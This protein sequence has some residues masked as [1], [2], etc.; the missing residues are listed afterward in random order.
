MVY[1]E[2][3]S[4]WSQQEIEADLHSNGYDPLCINETPD[5]RLTPHDHPRKHI[6]VVLNG[7]IH[8]GI[9]ETSEMLYSGDMAVIEPNVTHAA[10]FGSE[11]CRY[12]W[13]EQ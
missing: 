13:V 8:L 5:T 12:Y 6:I 10:H 4:G 9:S 1:A 3:Y 11:G 7:V 2:H